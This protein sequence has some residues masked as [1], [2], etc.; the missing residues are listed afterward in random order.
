M[1]DLVFNNNADT[2]PETYTDKCENI[3]YT[4]SETYSDRKIL[5]FQ[6]P[7]ALSLFLRTEWGG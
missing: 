7:H 3:V 4:Y 5:V 2:D 1:P 6:P